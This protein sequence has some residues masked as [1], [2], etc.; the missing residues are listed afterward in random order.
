MRDPRP[1]SRAIASS[2]G[3]VRR[4]TS[5]NTSAPVDPPKTLGSAASRP[6]RLGLEGEQPSGH[7]QD[8][9]EQP[10]GVRAERGPHLVLAQVAPRDE[11]G[12]AVAPEGRELRREAAHGLAREI[13]AGRRGTRAA[14]RRPPSTPPSGCRP[15]GARRGARPRPRRSRAKPSF[16]ARSPRDRARRI[17][18]VEDRREGEQAGPRAASS[19]AG[20]ASMLG[21][22]PLGPACVRLAVSGGGGVRRLSRDGPLRRRAPASRRSPSSRRRSCACRRRRCARATPLRSRSSRRGATISSSSSSSSSGSSSDAS[23]SAGSTASISSSGDGRGR[24]GGRTAH[25]TRCSAS[26]R[27]C[28]SSELTG[29]AMPGAACAAARPR[30]APHRRGRRAHARRRQ[31]GAGARGDSAPAGMTG[32][33]RGSDARLAGGTR[34]ARARRRSG[35]APPDEGLDLLDERGDV[36]GAHE[37]PAA[38]VR[39]G[40]LGARHGAAGPPEKEDV[41][42]VGAR[43]LA[44]AGG[45]VERAGAVG[46]EQDDPRALHGDARDQH[47]L[48]HVDDRA[49]RARA[50]PAPRARPRPSDR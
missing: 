6:G 9:R 19:R 13:A 21:G 36:D 17:A 39:E 24:L 15:R 47:R 44:H 49:T 14:T 46:V 37:E 29:G 2:G 34:V 50:A 11:R 32:V 20:V 7:L 41:D 3:T 5:T 22:L 10:L 16:A 26:A 27:S 1:P 23:S 38:R 18:R 30:P 48:R 28:C 42:V 4:T 43:D 8:A 40:V 25:C 33:E 12:A 45:H 31:R 35:A